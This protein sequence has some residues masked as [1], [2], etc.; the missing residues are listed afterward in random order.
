MGIAEFNMK[1][2]E[3]SISSARKIRSINRPEVI[4]PGIEPIRKPLPVRKNITQRMQEKYKIENS[5]K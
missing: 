3:K 2:Y 4:I 5:K 1:F